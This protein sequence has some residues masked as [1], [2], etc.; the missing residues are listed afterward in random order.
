[1][2][3]VSFYAETICGN[4]NKNLS[5]SDCFQ[6]FSLK[7]PFITSENKSCLIELM[8]ALISV[9]EDCAEII[10]D[11][12]IPLTK[13]SPSLRDH[14]ILLLRKALYSR[15]CKHFLLIR[16]DIVVIS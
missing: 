15:Y 7:F 6:Q 16:Y 11:I 2:R 1:M 9:S 8:E 10:L 12:I 13:V 5:I 4:I 14:L 3:K